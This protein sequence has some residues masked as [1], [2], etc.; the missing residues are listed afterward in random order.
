M[1]FYK[2]LKKNGSVGYQTAANPVDDPELIELTQNEY[3]AEIA[4]YVAAHQ[5]PETDE[6]TEADLLDALTD[7]GVIP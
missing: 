6:A 1:K 7:L 2:R 4:A 3:E 5:E